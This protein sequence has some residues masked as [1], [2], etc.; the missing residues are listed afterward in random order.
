MTMRAKKP[1]TTDGTPASSSR[2]GLTNSRRRP[3][4]YSE[5]KMAAP[6]LI[7]T[8]MTSETI[9]TLSD[10]AMSGH[11]LYLGTSLTGCHM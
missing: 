11:T 7:G 5:T 8:A 3:V 6:T 10:P 4:A 2:A 9:V 1:T